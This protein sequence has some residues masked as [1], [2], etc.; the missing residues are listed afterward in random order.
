MF[1]VSLAGDHLYGKWQFTRLLLIPSLTVSNLC[2][3]FSH[4]MSWTELRQLLKFFLPTFVVFSKDVMKFHT[5]CGSVE[6]CV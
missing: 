1:N 2:I 5:D 4:E 6:K 3:P